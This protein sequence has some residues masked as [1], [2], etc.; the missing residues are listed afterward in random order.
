MGAVR[1]FSPT[2]GIGITDGQFPCFTHSKAGTEVSL[3]SQPV[4]IAITHDAGRSWR[5]VGQA[6]PTGPL[7]K[8]QVIEQLVATSPTHLWAL[9]ATDACLKQTIAAR[10]GRF[11]RVADPS[12][13]ITRG[14]AYV[15]ALSCAPATSSTSP[16]ACRPQL[17]RAAI[18]TRAWARVA[19]PE[20]T[21]QAAEFVHLAISPDGDMMLNVFTAGRSVNGTLL[22]S[23]DAGRH[24]RVRPDPMWDRQPCTLGGWL[25]AAAPHTFWLLCIGGAAAGSSTKGLL[26]TTNAGTT[27]STVAVAPSLTAPPASRSIT[28]EEPSAL[29]AGSGSRLWLALVNGLDQSDTGGLTWSMVPPAAVDPSGWTTTISVLDARHA[30]VLAPGAGMWRTT[31]G[32]DWQVIGPLNTGSASPNGAP[33]RGVRGQ[34]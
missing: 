19:L 28:L 22:T 8:P 5:L 11:P 15:W 20:I 29:A 25:T 6:A 32:H 16:S 24:W 26:R 13:E 33:L 21:A 2:S 3:R 27:W 9:S 23:T 4:R 18:Q 14:G 30:W 10:T 34:I 12:V 7:P 17:W 31:D 1:F